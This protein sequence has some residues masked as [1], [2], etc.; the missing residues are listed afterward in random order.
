ML[1]IVAL[2]CAGQAVYDGVRAR[3]LGKSSVSAV[4]QPLPN[5]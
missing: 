1:A 2:V 5:H 3:R 4:S